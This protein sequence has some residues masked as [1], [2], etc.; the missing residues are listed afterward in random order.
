[1]TKISSAIFTVLLVLIC[2]TTVAQKAKSAN[3]L[4]KVAQKKASKSNK[5]VMVKYTATWCGWCHKM[6]TAMADK[7]I[8]AYFNANYEV[9]RIHI[10]ETK[11]K[12]QLEHKNGDSLFLAHGG[13]DNT[14]IPYWTI[15]DK[16]NKVLANSKMKATD[17]PL[18]GDG[19]NVGCPASEKE[20][21]YFIRVLKATGNFSEEA[22]EKI[23]ARFR[24]IE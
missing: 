23:T 16:N 14:G 12:K 8:A 20:V 4:I 5:K 1:M 24:K 7:A 15:L 22:I 10:K 21:A 2:S 18:D 17:Q 9:V 6:D 13:T 3:A 11:D 19:D